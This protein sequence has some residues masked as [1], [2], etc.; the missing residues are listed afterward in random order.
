M[1]ASKDRM[2]ALQQ[3][4]KEFIVVENHTRKSSETYKDS[5]CQCYDFAEQCAKEGLIERPEDL[6]NALVEI[7]KGTD[8]AL[9]LF[10]FAL[11]FGVQ[12]LEEING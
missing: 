9:P 11:G 10:A 3:K 5:F 8:A 2:V 4:M 7:V 1:I 12:S 6:L